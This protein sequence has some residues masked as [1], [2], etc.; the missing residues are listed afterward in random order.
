MSG[1][2]DSSIAAALLQEQGCS[3]AGFTM[4]LASLGLEHGDVFAAGVDCARRVAGELG[5]PH[6]VVD[7]SKTFRVEVIEPFVRAYAAGRTPNPCVRCNRMLKFRMLLECADTLGAEL[8]ATGHY[9]RVVR[10]SDGSVH[11]HAATDTSRD[12]SYFLYNLTRQQLQRARFPLGGMTKDAVR[13][14]AR[15]LGIHVA[16]RDDSQEICFIPDKDYGAY[17]RRHFPETLKPGAIKHI[18]GEE[19]GTHPGI[20]FYTIGQRKGIG[21]HGARKFVVRIESGSGDVIIGDNADLMATGLTLEDVNW[22]IPP[23]DREFR[24]TTKI[25]SAMRAAPCMVHAG[26]TPVRVVFEKA[27]RAITPGQACVVYVGDEVM[28]GGL[29]SCQGSGLRV[30]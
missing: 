5:I 23:P 8:V 13:E 20:Q 11:L 10:D 14:H 16:D 22:I 25:R 12:Q 15:T 18:S 28:G 27:Q 3:V 24:A 17:V 19:V 6:H 26:E 30:Q 9:A 4:S 1:G 29:I 7:V 2:V 21:A